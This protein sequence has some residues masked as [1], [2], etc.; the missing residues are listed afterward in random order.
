MALAEVKSIS[1]LVGRIVWVQTNTS[2]YSYPRFGK[3]LEEAW[4]ELLFNMERL[5]KK[6]VTHAPI[7]L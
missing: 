6:W 7:K 3:T 2:T 4:E 1:D 5:R